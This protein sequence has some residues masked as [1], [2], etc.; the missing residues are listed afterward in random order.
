MGNFTCGECRAAEISSFSCSSSA[1]LVREGDFNSVLELASGA[2]GTAKGRAEFARL[3]RLWV[4]LVV[5]KDPTLPVGAVVMPRHSEESFISFLRWLVTDGDRARS[6]QTHFRSAA[7]ALAILDGVQN[8]TLLPRV[9]AVVKELTSKLGVTA[10]PDTHVTRRILSVLFSQ[11][12]RQ[13]SAALRTKTRWLAVL[14][15]MAGVRVGEACGGGDGHGA[16]ANH[17]S[18][19]NPVNSTSESDEFCELWIPDSKTC[20][21]RYVNFMGR[22]RGVGVDAADSL[23]ALLTEPGVRMK[24]TV[25]DGLVVETPDY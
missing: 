23:R 10:V 2:E 14:E 18:F 21:P 13:V 15:V 9:K 5:A 4:A 1:A 25:E 7:G 22:S 8:W 20:F 6:F 16:L 12:L 24:E 17:L 11:T 3:E 19:M